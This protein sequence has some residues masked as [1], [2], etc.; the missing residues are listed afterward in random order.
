LSER[1]Q[2]QEEWYSRKAKWNADRATR[3]VTTSIVLEFAGLLGGAAKAFDKTVFGWVDV[4]LLGVFA[5][6]AAAATAWL[7][8][9]QHENLATAYGVTSQELAAVGS[10]VEMQTDETTWPQ[11]VSTAE[12]AISREHT[13]WRASRGI[14]TKPSPS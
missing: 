1:I 13:L 8:A 12:E 5:A 3:W 6:A 11:F 14:H 10:E 2:N 9:K 7:Q 4:D